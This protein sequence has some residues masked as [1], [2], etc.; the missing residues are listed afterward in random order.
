MWQ[1]VLML[2]QFYTQEDPQITSY[3]NHEPADH[4]YR[5]D[6]F[7]QLLQI[8]IVGKEQGKYDPD[9]KEWPGFFDPRA[10]KLTAHR[11]KVLDSEFAVPE[12][13]EPL[14]LVPCDQE[15][16]YDKLEIH[17]KDGWAI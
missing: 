8:N 16:H 1:F 11:I 17:N 10:G 14:K 12:T 9:G 4:V 5:L 7:K 15:K 3:F 13:R 6:E 2:Q